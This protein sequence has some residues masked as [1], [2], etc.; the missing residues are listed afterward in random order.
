MKTLKVFR[1]VVIVLSIG[2]F[3]FLLVP[4]EYVKSV[5]YASSQ[6]AGCDKKVE[7]AVTQRIAE[8][9]S[10]EVD[11]DLMEAIEKSNE[12]CKPETYGMWNEKK[13]CVPTLNDVTVGGTGY[14]SLL[15]RMQQ[16]FILY[17]SF[18]GTCADAS[19]SRPECAYLSLYNATK[20]S[21]VLRSV[22]RVT[23]DAADTSSYQ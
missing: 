19:Q 22:V 5:S 3:V 9:N 15:E 12:E 8:L 23:L 10:E 7:K 4:N 2:G 16:D 13:E 11:S 17:R 1:F 20:L 14:T 21:E 6:G 18:P